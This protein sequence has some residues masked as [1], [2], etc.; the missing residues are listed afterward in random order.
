MV[1]SNEPGHS[2]AWGIGATVAGIVF[3]LIACDVIRL[4]EEARGG[5]AGPA[6]AASLPGLAFVAAGLS[7]LFRPGGRLRSASAA[8]VFLML[9]ATAGW[10]A[11]LSK[12]GFFSEV[13]IVP[14]SGSANVLVSRSLFGVAALVGG[15]VSV[16][17]LRRLGRARA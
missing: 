13:P 17:A 9:T 11:F 12:D 1:E 7:M 6:W 14:F 4:G 8:A 10:I 16:A 5:F 15:A 2:P 3:V